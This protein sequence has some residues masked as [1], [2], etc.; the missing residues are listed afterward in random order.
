MPTD[1]VMPHTKC[2]F[3]DKKQVIGHPMGNDNISKEPTIPLNNCISKIKEIS[4]VY[5]MVLGS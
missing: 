2:V 3:E 5:S 4:R 1:F